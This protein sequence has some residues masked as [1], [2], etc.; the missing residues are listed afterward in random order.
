MYNPVFKKMCSCYICGF[1]MCA[2]RFL[3]VFSQAFSYACMCKIM[4]Q[5]SYISF[6]VVIFILFLFYA[7]ISLLSS[8]PPSGFH[9]G[10]T[11]LSH[12]STCQ[13]HSSQLVLPSTGL[14]C[15]PIYLLL[16][17]QKLPIIL[18]PLKAV[19]FPL[20]IWIYLSKHAPPPSLEI[21]SGGD[22]QIHEFSHPSDQSI[23]YF[24]WDKLTA[25]HNLKVLQP[26]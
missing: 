6:Y 3:H 22:W 26:R 16:T 14:L 9:P 19:H 24:L 2:L 18:G 12:L 4:K 5:K 17:F 1:K 7:H 25:F 20:L 8:D 10:N 15:S 21:I 23:Y 11:A 13:P